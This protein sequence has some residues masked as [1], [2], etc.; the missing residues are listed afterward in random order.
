[1]EH[2]EGIMK[3]L[4][5]VDSTRSYRAAGEVAGCDH[6]IVAHSVARHDAGKRSRPLAA[7]SPTSSSRS[8]SG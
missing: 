8:S 6:H 7:R 3:T 1:M 2:A 4:D 5:T